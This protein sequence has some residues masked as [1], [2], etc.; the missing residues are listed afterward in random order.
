MTTDSASC[1]GLGRDTRGADSGPGVREGEGEAGVEGVV[2]DQGVLGTAGA[3]G[4]NAT[5][6]KRPMDVASAN[7]RARGAKGGQRQRVH[8]NQR[9]GGNV[10]SQ[11]AVAH[12]VVSMGKAAPSDLTV[13][14]FCAAPVRLKVETCKGACLR[15]AT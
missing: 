8:W 10:E 2:P 11:P 1:A 12:G 6:T 3:E 5:A 9:Q 14:E 15:R 4:V 13:N 7:G